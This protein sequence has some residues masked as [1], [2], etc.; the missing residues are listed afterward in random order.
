MQLP[1]GIADIAL[2]CF[3]MDGTLAGADHQVT[4][5]TLR[6][7]ADLEGTGVRIMIITG[8][9][10]PEALAV[11]EKGGFGGTAITSNGAVVADGATGRVVEQ[12]G[13]DPDVIDAAIDFVSDKE[14]EVVLFTATQHWVVPGSKVA[15]ILTEVNPSVETLEVSRAQL[16]LGAV[17]KMCFMANAPVLEAHEAQIRARF[18]GAVRSMDWIFDVS[19]AGADKGAAMERFLAANG[20]LPERVAGVGD[21]END[22]AWLRLVGHPVAVANALPAVKEVTGLTIGH[23]A[24]EG[25]AELVE[26]IVAARRRP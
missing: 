8:R 17:T 19:P 10:L 12:A 16:D 2:M 11:F 21:S 4:P 7:L 5:R 13:L 22:I 23:H 1:D 25:V 14:M 15:S 20:I 18:P 3:D 9:A 26:A 24:E 6:A